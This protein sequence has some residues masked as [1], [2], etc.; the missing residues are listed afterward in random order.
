MFSLESF[1]CVTVHCAV[2]PVLLFST[3]L[4][5]VMRC[6]CNSAC[7]TEIVRLHLVMRVLG[8][9]VLDT[10]IKF[11]YHILALSSFQTHMHSFPPPVEHKRR[12]FEKQSS[13]MDKFKHFNTVLQ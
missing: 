12:Y 2:I 9:I 4:V 3:L 11:C 6:E 7:L 1:P 8:G 10:K 13:K 5:G